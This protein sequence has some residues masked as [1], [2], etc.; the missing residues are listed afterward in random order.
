[1]LHLDRPDAGE[2]GPLGQVAVADDLVAACLVPQIGAGFEVGGDL[3]LDGLGEE[4][5]RSPAED[6]VTER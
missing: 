5:R 3:G 4:L 6:L 2:E 1:L